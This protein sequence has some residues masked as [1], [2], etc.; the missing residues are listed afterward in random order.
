MAD[1]KRDYYEVL[2]VEKGASDADIKKAYRQM[3]KKY[4]PDL[5]PGDKVAEEKFK[6]VGEAYEVLSDSEKRAR[7]DQFGHA[8]VDPNFGAGGPGGAYNVDFGDLGDIFSTFFG[9]GFGGGGRANPNA[10]RR[11]S[12]LS[13]TVTLSFEEAAK[14]C[15][16]DVEYNRIETCN[17]CSGSG[18]QPGTSPKTCTDCGGSGF[19]R[20]NQR[21]PF[22]VIQSQHACNTCQGTGKIVEHKCSK[23]SGL[24]KVRVRT[25]RSVEFPAGV[26]EGQKVRVSGAGNQ[27]SNSGTSGDLY[28]NVDIRPHHIFERQGYDVHMEQP[29][30]YGQAVF[31][32]DIEVPTLDGP[33]KIKVPAGTQPGDIN[34]MQGKGIQRLNSRSKGDQYVHFTV[35]VPKSV[36]SEQRD[37][38]MQLEKSMGTDVSKF[39]N[40]RFPFQKK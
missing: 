25:T 38:I 13:K 23:C 35:V 5:N 33:V 8:G 20:V 9:G 22:G 39:K 32:A 1:T 6:E 28:V 10:P 24:G 16:K 15:T 2:G 26:D 29:I 36:T 31:G 40:S 18:A 4:H 27:G 17:Q 30:T 7:Y 37:L 34:R 3:A 11:G 14:G 12:D 19:V 21:T